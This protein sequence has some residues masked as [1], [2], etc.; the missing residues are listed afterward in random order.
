MPPTNKTIDDLRQAVF[1]RLR[2]LPVFPAAVTIVPE[3]RQNIATEV[4]KG[5]GTGRGLVI[6]IYTGDARNIAPASPVPQCETEIIIEIGEV[7]AINRGRA[8]T[9]VPGVEAARYCVRA[10]HQ[11]PWTAGR[12]LTFTEQEYN[13]DAKG[14]VVQYFLTFKTQVSFDA[15]IGVL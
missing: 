9:G 7:P 11:F 4:A 2:S 8:G 12:A 3:D 6:I 5:L 15:E 13:R 1:E 10:L 14:S